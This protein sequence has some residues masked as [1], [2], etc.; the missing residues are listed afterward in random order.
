M[1]QA[2]ELRIGNLVEYTPFT[3]VSEFTELNLYN[4]ADL[5]G[6]T[7]IGKPEWKD[8][9]NPIPLT[10]DILSKIGV[11][12]MVMDDTNSQ[13]WLID[14]FLYKEDELCMSKGLHW[15]QNFHYFKTG[16]ELEINL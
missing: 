1:I 3:G 9:Y 14:D 2:N 8:R 16:R 11:S 15:L 4:L 13:Y 5:L 12:K 6:D 10:K 7:R